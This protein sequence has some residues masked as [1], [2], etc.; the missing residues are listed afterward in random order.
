MDCPKLKQMLRWGK[1]MTAEKQP[2]RKKRKKT[3]RQTNF[4]QWVQQIVSVKWIP[5]CWVERQH[6]T[7]SVL[8]SRGASKRT[9][10]NGRAKT[11]AEVDDNSQ[12]VARICHHNRLPEWAENTSAFHDLAA[13]DETLHAGELIASRKRWREIERRT[14]FFKAQERFGVKSAQDFQKISKLL[15]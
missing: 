12:G 5:F 14:S 1:Y 15:W 13:G 3:W 11:A 9:D 10:F 4:H 7:P 6:S 8:R 2:G